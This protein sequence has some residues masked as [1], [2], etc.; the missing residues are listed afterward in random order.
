VDGVST[1]SSSP[2]TMVVRSSTVSG[3]RSGASRSPTPARTNNSGLGY[4]VLQAAPFV[5]RP[6]VVLNGDN[7]FS[8]D[9]EPALDRATATEVDTV[10]LVKETSEEA[11]GTGL[12]K[13][14]EPGHLPV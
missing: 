2:D 7:V 6:F 11:A 1:N 10:L 8:E 5:D 3:T 14:E 12:V 4:A 9:I 13:V